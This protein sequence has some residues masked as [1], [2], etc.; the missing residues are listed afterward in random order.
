MSKTTR[1]KTLRINFTIGTLK[2]LLKQK[3][4]QTVYDE[5]TKSLG[6][7]I[8]PT[9][10]A[11]FFWFRK[12][13]G[14]PTWKHI[15]KYSDASIEEARAKAHSFDSELGKWELNN[16]EGLKPAL[17]GQKPR[18][19]TLNDVLED[20]LKVHLQ[21]EA[22]NPDKAVRICRWQFNRYLSQ[23]KDA[24]LGQISE[25]EVRE[26][27]QEIGSKHGKS[28]PKNGK[29]TV[30]ELKH[31][32]YTAN[33][34][35]GLLRTLF[36]WAIKQKMWAGANPAAGIKRFKEKKRKRYI[37]QSADE[38]P[39]FF[40]AVLAE[41]NVDLRDFL[42]LALF[43]GARR[44]N[45]LGMRWDQMN[46]KNATWDIPD[47]KNDEPYTVALGAEAVAVLRS[48]LKDRVKDNPWVFPSDSSKCGHLLDLKRGWYKLRTKAKLPDVRVHD[49]RRTLGS[50]QAGSGTSLQIIGKSLGHGSLESTQVYSHLELAPVRAAVEAATAAMLSAAKI[51]STKL[52]GGQK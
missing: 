14:R 31:G 19:R 41:K 27:H 44:S 23:W 36:N 24:K 32:R 28:G 11:S 52:L 22:K 49:L 12:V 16:Y 8:Q 15:A 42:L 48:R 34:V 10:R 37:G 26:L 17:L 20:Y 30:T 29:E 6:L 43:T 3:K 18:S 51:T 1:Q 47:P 45:V 46:L 39:R 50:W 21:Q 9:G 38:M 25:D 7:L 33:R 35:I 13:Q 2:P 40:K 5:D 4:R